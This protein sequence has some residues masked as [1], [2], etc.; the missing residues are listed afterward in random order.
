[1]VPTPDTIEE[2]VQQIWFYMVGMNGDG[3]ISKVNRINEKVENIESSLPQFVTR[4][5][6]HEEQKAKTTK[7]TISWQYWVALVMAFAGNIVNGI[8][9]MA[10]K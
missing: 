6:I 10:M 4:S 9:W 8:L 5:E 7:K 2:K 3:M 1:M